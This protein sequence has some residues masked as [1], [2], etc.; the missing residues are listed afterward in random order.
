MENSKA[1]KQNSTNKQT[2]KIEN[3]YSISKKSVENNN[4]KPFFSLVLVKVGIIR[5]FMSGILCQREKALT[6]N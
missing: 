1:L 4:K 5:D 2:E 6:L 3:E